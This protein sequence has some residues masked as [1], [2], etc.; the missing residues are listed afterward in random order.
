M[1]RTRHYTVAALL[2]LQGVACVAD[3]AARPGP[4]QDTS[5][6]WQWVYVAGLENPALSPEAEHAVDVLGEALDR[7]GIRWAAGGSRGYSL[8]IDSRDLPRGR[9][10]L[11]EVVDRHRLPVVVAKP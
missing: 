4:T 8:S 7:Q 1:T 9:E 10:I 2:W 5:G 6:A 11:Q 3:D